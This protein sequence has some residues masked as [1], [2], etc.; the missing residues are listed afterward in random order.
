MTVCTSELTCFC[1]YL[2][3]I[4]AFCLCVW[5]W[6][7]YHDTDRQHLF[8]IE[9]VMT[10][11]PCQPCC[12]LWEKNLWKRKPSLKIIFQPSQSLSD[13]LTEGENLT[14]LTIFTSKVYV[15]AQLTWVFSHSWQGSSTNI[16]LSSAPSFDIIVNRLCGL[17]AS[18]KKLVSQSVG[19]LVA[20]G[21]G[22]ISMEVA[23]L[24]RFGSKPTQSPFTPL[25]GTL[26]HCAL[27]YMYL[28]N[29]LKSVPSHVK[30]H[31]KN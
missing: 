10:K 4:Y 27:R 23:C 7:C 6:Y 9:N 8:F 25:K 28:K 3:G 21:Q 2:L 24:W 11:L 17:W 30:E 12:S 22:H 18:L 19:S 15:M 29:V 5:L 31:S 26:W 1:K 20:E 13:I 14:Y 16:F